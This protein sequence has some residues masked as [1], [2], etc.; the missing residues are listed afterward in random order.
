MLRLLCARIVSQ[1]H[2]PAWAAGCLITGLQSCPID[3]L[4]VVAVFILGVAVGVSSFWSIY[5]WAKS[6]KKDLL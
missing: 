1:P 3:P 6:N 5:L 4:A 2:D